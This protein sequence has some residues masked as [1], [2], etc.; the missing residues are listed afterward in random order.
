MTP[1]PKLVWLDI[2]TTG[3]DPQHGVIFEMGIIVTDLELKEHARSSWVL[4]HA[5]SRVLNLMDD[6]VLNMHMTNGLLK[7]VW[8][9]PNEHE[10]NNEFAARLDKER[11]TKVNNIV[12]WIQNSTGETTPRDCYMAG[13]SIHFDRA[14]LAVHYPKI[15]EQVS[16][17]MVDVSS[18]KVAFPDLLTQP[19][20]PE[21]RALGDLEYSIN[22][23][24]QMREKL[25]L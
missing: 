18:F 20:K 9:V 13:S 15:L 24:A 1:A 6:Y 19:N 7:E 25:G 4:R 17:R 23:L 10:A 14:W 12:R 21:H 2:E 11:R 8:G 3:L 22:Q 5:R 16:Y